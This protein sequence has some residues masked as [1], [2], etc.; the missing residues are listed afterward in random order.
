MLKLSKCS[1]LVKRRIPFD[2]KKVDGDKMDSC[3]VYVENFPEQLT[4][5][6]IAKLFSRA[7]EIR[8]V[9]VP[10]FAGNCVSK[11]FCFVEFNCEEAANKACELFNNCI[12]EEFT[13][14]ECKNY[15]LVQGNLIQLNVIS[16]KQWNT[17]KEEAKQIKREIALLN[18]ET[19]FA[20]N[21][22]DRKFCF[23]AGTLVS[24]I[25]NKAGQFTKQLL[26][27]ATSHF[28]SPIHIDLF[29]KNSRQATIRFGS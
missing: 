17:F 21:E 7:G 23:D 14:S 27:E 2:I 1:K 10:K 22:G 5:Q 9:R 12:P 19:M 3:T 8:N 4:H 13:N 15:I 18:P 24:L 20:A 26:K 16:K 29:G 28:G 11:G 25:F 6:E